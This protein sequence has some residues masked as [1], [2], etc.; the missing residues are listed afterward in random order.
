MSIITK[1]EALYYTKIEEEIE[2]EEKESRKFR[3][4]FERAKKDGA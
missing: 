3:K 4:F 2:N 1:T